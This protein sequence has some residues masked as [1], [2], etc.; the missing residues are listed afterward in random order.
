MPGFVAGARTYFDDA[1]DHVLDLA[2]Q[3]AYVDF[4]F[5]LVGHDVERVIAF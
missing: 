2:D 3:F 5:K 4:L 1:N